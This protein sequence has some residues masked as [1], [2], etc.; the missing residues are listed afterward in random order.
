[1]TKYLV[2][3]LGRSGVSVAN[4]LNKNENMYAVYDKD[5]K[6]AQDFIDKGLLPKNCE[7]V[8]KLCA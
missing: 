6:K 4:F 5:K 7:I 2:V 1:M 3:G 8:A